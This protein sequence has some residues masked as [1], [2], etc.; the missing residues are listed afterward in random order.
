MVLGFYLMLIGVLVFAAN[1]GIDVPHGVWNYWPFLLI[2]G[3]GMRMILSPSVGEG[4]WL[5]LA[6][7]YCWVSTWNL[8]GL[9]WGTAWP[10]FLVAGGLSMVL[11][12][13]F[14]DGK[15]RGRRDDADA[16]DG[17]AAGGAVEGG[18]RVG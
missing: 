12:P 17:G 16:L 1:L 7:L 10:I 8:W 15:R 9:T 2:A 5:L 18:D 4:Y 14:G 13:W 11:E 6:G 3:G